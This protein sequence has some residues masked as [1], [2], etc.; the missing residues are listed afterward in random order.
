MITILGPLTLT[1]EVLRRVIIYILSIYDIKKLRSSSKIKI[2]SKL[3]EDVPSIF[4]GYALAST[5][6]LIS[7]SS[8][9]QHNFDPV[10]VGSI[11]VS[12]ICSFFFRIVVVFYF[13]MA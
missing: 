7:F 5:R 6:I 8:Q 13:T 9:A 12:A 4:N 11:I 10:Y 3:S 2:D 1:M